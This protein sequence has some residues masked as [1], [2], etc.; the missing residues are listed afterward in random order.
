MVRPSSAGIAQ[1]PTAERLPLHR[2]ERGRAPAFA[3]RERV[4]TSDEKIKWWRQ[5]AEEYRAA[6]ENVQNPATRKTYINL[7]QNYDVLADREQ[8]ILFAAHTR[9]KYKG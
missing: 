8:S 1:A 4:Q 9:F 7:A 2:D 5:R 3:W 6:A